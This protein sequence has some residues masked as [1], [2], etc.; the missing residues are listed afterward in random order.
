MITPALLILASASLIATVLVRLARVVDRV[1]KLAD[2]GNEPWLVDEVNRQERRAFLA[3]RAL[4]FFFLAVTC[5]VIAGLSIAIDRALGNQ[6]WWMPVVIT[7]I[8]MALIVGGCAAML[9][10]TRLSVS[11]LRAEIARLRA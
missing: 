1:R 7:T 6:L 4:S 8:G 9:V 5:F 2:L 10:E 11:Q 3:E